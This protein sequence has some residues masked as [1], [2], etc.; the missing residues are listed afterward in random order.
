MKY[1]P[2]SVEEAFFERHFEYGDD[3]ETVLSN[4]SKAFSL[5]ESSYKK[6]TALAEKVEDGE[7]YDTSEAILQF[8]TLA[9]SREYLEGFLKDMKEEVAK[10]YREKIKNLLV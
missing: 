2:E 7:C 6:V 10:E 1:I 5:M 3:E 8:Q 4:A 9:L